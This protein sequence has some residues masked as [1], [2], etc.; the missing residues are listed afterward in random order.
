M[1]PTISENENS[2]KIVTSKP[3]S[4]IHDAKI[5]MYK[6]KNINDWKSML[7]ILLWYRNYHMQQ[8]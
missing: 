1:K 4:K 7:Y 2:S 5:V 8:I 6:F 3:S